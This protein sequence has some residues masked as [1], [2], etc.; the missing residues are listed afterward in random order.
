MHQPWPSLNADEPDEGCYLAGQLAPAGLYRDV[1]RGRDLSL[2]TDDIL[3]A[4]CDGRVAL[5]VRR[6]FVWAARSSDSS[7]A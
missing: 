2:E 4:T 5:Y 1:Y 7:N 6:E 3:P